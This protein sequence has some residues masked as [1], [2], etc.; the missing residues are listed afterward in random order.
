[1]GYFADYMDDDDDFAA[2]SRS[3]NRDPFTGHHQTGTRKCSKCLEYKTTKD[4]NKVEAKK[5]ASKR[6]CNA[7]GPPLPSD[8]SILTVVQIKAELTKHGETNLVGKKA[9]LIA[10]L[11][12]TLLVANANNTAAETTITHEEQTSAS[13]NSSG[14]TNSVELANSGSDIVMDVS[15]QGLTLE[16]IMSLKVV[17]L[18]KEL[19]ARGLP[20]GGL[21][22]ALQKRLVDAETAPSTTGKDQINKKEEVSDVNALEAKMS[23]L[24]CVDENKNFEAPQS[25]TS[26]ENTLPTSSNLVSTKKM[27][28]PINNKKVTIAEQ[29]ENDRENVHNGTSSMKRW[30]KVPPP[31]T[32]D[33][34]YD[35]SSK[36]FNGRTFV[37]CNKCKLWTGHKTAE[38]IKKKKSKNNKKKAIP[39]IPCNTPGGRPLGLPMTPGTGRVLAERP[40][41]AALNQR[42]LF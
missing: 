15:C 40:N 31:K 25:K 20:V 12:Q 9:E 13:S 29:S 8:L 41:L 35:D 39:L 3:S 5:P 16:Y 11:E 19:K 36:A 6:I 23:N 38:H 10:R 42:A 34:A 22:A 33:G 1:M 18:K 21:K 7:C 2:S 26:D 14:P 28:V 30:K 32:S 24:T 37:W 27:C 17:D 4:F